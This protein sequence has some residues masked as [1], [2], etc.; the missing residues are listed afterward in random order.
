M[1]KVPSKNHHFERAVKDL[2]DHLYAN[3]ELREPE[4]LHAE[5]AK[6]LTVLIATARSVAKGEQSLFSPSATASSHPDASSI[7]EAYANGHGGDEIALDDGSIA[8]VDTYLRGIDLA[9][10]ERDFVGDALETMRPMVAK[11]LGGQFF[12]D[13]RVTHLAVDLLDYD[14]A[15]HDFID[16]CAGTGGFLIAAAGRARKM[17][18]NHQPIA[19]T[20]IDPK[21]ASLAQRALSQLDSQTLRV[22]RQDALK[23]LPMWSAEA[24]GLV[25]ENAHL[26]LASNP[27]FGIKITVRDPDSLSTFGLARTWAKRAGRWEQASRIVPRPP[28]LLFIERNLQLAQP[29][30]GRVAIVVPYQVLSGPRLGFVREWLL[31]HARVLAVVDLP[32]HTFQPWTGTKTCLLVFERRAE[33]L[34]RSNARNDGPVFMATARH[35]GHDRRGNPVVDDNDEIQTDLPEVAAAWRAFSDGGSPSSEHVEAFSIDSTHIRQEND[36]RLNAAFHHPRPTSLRNKIAAP[37]DQFEV[38]RL[39]DVVESVW[40]PGR[41]KRRYTDDAST[42]VPFLGGASISQFF[43]TTTKFLRPDDPRLAELVV[44][45]GLILVTR[46]GSTGIVS[47]VPHAWKGWAV[48]EHVIRIAPDERRLSGDYLEAFLRSRYGKEL[49]AAGVFGSVIDEITPEYIAE[50][51]VPI[52]RDAQTL[53]RIVESQS[54]ANVAR[55][56]VASGIALSLNALDNAFGRQLRH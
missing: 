9:S 7:R 33:A 35:I 39:G 50:L 14:P 46:S 13:Q 48:S 29:G 51:R 5:V 52:P 45:E 40:C 37:S 18:G 34:E 41:F 32:E 12:T 8:S 20:E 54:A 2:H 4:A 15:A 16:V 49:M 30:V 53:A 11:R 6:V 47:R 42:G 22:A 19:G 21:I 27:P 1:Q 55:D 36:L 3:S 25:R 31:R 56:Q 17:G 10:A 23:P 44:E 43:V 26:R 38:V 24:G 28:D